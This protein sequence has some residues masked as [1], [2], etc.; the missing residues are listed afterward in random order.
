MADN[1]SNTPIYLLSPST[2]LM[3]KVIRKG[4]SKFKKLFGDKSKKDKEK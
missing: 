4:E 3:L 2:K 1:G